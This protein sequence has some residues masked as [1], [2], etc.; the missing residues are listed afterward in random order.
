MN[1]IIQTM[2]LLVGMLALAISG[3]HDAPRENPFDPESGQLKILEG[4]YRI[5]TQEDLDALAAE[6]GEAFEINGDLV[7]NGSPLKTLEGLENLVRVHGDLDIGRLG[8]RGEP[9][10]SLQNLIGL[11]NLTSV[12]GTLISKVMSP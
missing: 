2:L 11:N 8:A 5:E 3:C 10:L 7:V 6:G 1:R 4:D 12:R 9:N